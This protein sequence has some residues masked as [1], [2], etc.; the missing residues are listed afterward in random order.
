[1]ISTNN[2]MTRQLKM[3]QNPRFIV[4]NLMNKMMKKED[5]F[6]QLKYCKKNLNMMVSMTFRSKR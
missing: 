2:I 6:Y 3:P 1:M 5:L 4:N